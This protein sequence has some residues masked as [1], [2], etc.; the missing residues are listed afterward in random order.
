MSDDEPL[1]PAT[2]RNL[3]I[4]LDPWRESGDEPLEPLDGENPGL[5]TDT[6]DLGS[7]RG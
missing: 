5:D 3:G 6:D 1:E 4:D 2:D 7:P